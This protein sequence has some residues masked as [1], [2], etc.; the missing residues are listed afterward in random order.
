MWV[1][2]TGTVL[3]LAF[4]I[5]VG[6]ALAS[7]QSKTVN[8]SPAGQTQPDDFDQRI[9]EYLLKNPEVV[10]EAI[11]RWQEHQRTA[12]ADQIKT[13]IASRSEEIFNDPDSPVGGNPDGD[14][15][16]V[17]FFDYNCPYCRKVA[18]VVNEIEQNDPKLWFVYKEFPVLGPDSVFAARAALASRKQ[19]K[20]V[21]FHKAMMQAD[22]RLTEDKIMQ[23]AK[24]SWP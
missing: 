6:L 2:R 11:Q 14:V 22:E 4:A 20:Y 15:A 12:Q 13:V 7:S 16:V 19:G 10:V 9:R 8:Q 1:L 5:W 23:I 17:E 18:P 24:T 21:A 3:V